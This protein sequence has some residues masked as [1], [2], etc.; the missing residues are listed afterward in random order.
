MQ[1]SNR[2][3]NLVQHELSALDSLPGL[4]NVVIYVA[5]TR[6]G[7]TPTL[8]VVGEMPG[9]SSKG[10]PP[11]ENDPDLR[12][13][14][15]NRRWYPLQDGSVVL[16]V[17]RAES[18]A[19]EEQWPEAL[20]KRL[21]SSSLVLSNFLNLELDRMRIFDE[22]SQQK[23]Q[24]Q[25]LVHQLRNPLTA[26]KT[27]AQLLMRKIEPE[28]NQR[29]LVEGLLSEQAQVNKYLLALDQL[30]KEK[31]SAKSFTQA[32][33]LLPPL[34][35][36]AKYLNLEEILNPLIDR[37]AATAKLQDRKWVGPEDWP[38][39]IKQERPISEGVIGEIVANLLE[40]AFKYSPKNASIGL[41][42]N[43]HGLCV[44]D[45]GQP[46]SS[47]FKEKIFLSGFRSNSADNISGSGLGLTLG[48]E[49]AQQLGGK[50]ELIVEPRNFHRSLPLEGNAFVLSLPLVMLLKEKA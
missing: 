28:S 41:C 6:N 31:E 34:L 30:S 4:E 32:S 33:L 29:D 50:L 2:F 42:F 39:W 21:Q 12:V 36:H 38:D 44:W 18:F 46:I 8:E 20:D 23:E 43:D 17:I 14:S 45:S 3:L 13:P 16:G 22:F 24:I 19:S 5:Q 25:M 47:E 15:P 11:I 48:R 37:A 9:N 27:Y 10:L 26:L 7:K 49:L 40:N 1:F 35:P